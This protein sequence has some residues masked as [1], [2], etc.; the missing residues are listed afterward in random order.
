VP[1]RS[2]C[3]TCGDSPAGATTQGM[4]EQ[5]DAPGMGGCWMG[6]STVGFVSG[7]PAGWIPPLAA[8]WGW[9]LGRGRAMS[10]PWGHGA[11]EAMAGW[12][13]RRFS[14]GSVAEHHPVSVGKQGSQGT[15]Y[16]PWT[17]SHQAGVS[18]NPVWFTNRAPADWCA[19]AAGLVPRLGF[20]LASNRL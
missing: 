9:G 16:G 13:C 12:K 14:A 1:P 17:G 3:D 8:I 4:E 18:R 7:S 6:E 11:R 20:T 5:G 19:G 10:R 2:L 15:Q